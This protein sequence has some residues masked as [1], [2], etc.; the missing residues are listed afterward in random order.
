MP[1]PFFKAKSRF[2]KLDLS[3]IITAAALYY[4]NTYILKVYTSGAL[5]YFCVCYFNDFL[6]ALLLLAYA[7]ILLGAVNSRFC[8]LSTILF[9]AVI[10]GFFWEF[11]SPPIKINRTADYI[12]ILYYCIG[13]AYYWGVCCYFKDSYILNKLCAL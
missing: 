5:N 10:V 12:D 11:W 1:L 4:L 7:N 9:I 13:A 2:N 8:K 3:V 6:A